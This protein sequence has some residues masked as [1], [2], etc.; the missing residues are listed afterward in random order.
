MAV[1][2]KETKQIAHRAFARLNTSYI[3]HLN[4]NKEGFVCLLMRFG[5]TYITVI[6]YGHACSHQGLNLHIRKENKPIDALGLGVG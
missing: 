5:G 2:N 1:A 6:L 4:S 3:C